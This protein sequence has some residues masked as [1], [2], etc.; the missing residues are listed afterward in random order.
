MSQSPYYAAPG[1]NNQEEIDWGSL[2]N[3]NNGSLLPM[4]PQR[5]DLS[6]GP[7][8]LQPQQNQTPSQGTNGGLWLT[9]GALAIFS[10]LG[11][12]FR[13]FLENL[14]GLSCISQSPAW[15]YIVSDKLNVCI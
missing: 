13:V 14:L 10:M 11:N 2:R 3:N 6:P 1:E 7:V 8:E 5:L 15:L 4:E 9:I 12:A